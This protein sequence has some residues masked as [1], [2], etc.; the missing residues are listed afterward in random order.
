ME[1]DTVCHLYPY[2]KLQNEEEFKKIW[3]AAYPDTKASQ[4]AEKSHQYAFSFEPICV[5]V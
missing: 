5:H 2:F 3:Y 4:E 1:L